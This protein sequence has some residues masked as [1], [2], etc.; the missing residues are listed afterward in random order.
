MNCGWVEAM[1]K[2]ARERKIRVYNA[3]AE[4]LPFEA[5]QF[6]FALMVTTI[7]FVDDIEKSFKEVKRIL[8]SGGLFII[9]FV[10]FKIFTSEI[11]ILKLLIILNGHIG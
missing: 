11:I 8:K 4:S 6:D 10:V 9:G 2:L 7:C 3:V 5:G 1:R